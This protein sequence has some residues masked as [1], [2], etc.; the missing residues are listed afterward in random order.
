MEG[1]YEKIQQAFKMQKWLF[2]NSIT[3]HQ[4]AG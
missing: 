3:E 2:K 1:N 4:P